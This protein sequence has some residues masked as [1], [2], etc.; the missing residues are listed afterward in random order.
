VPTTVAGFGQRFADD[1]QC[2]ADHGEVAAGPGGLL[3]LLDCREVDGGGSG[4]C[5]VHDV[6]L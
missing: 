5:G 1:L 3:H 4:G 2:R 6:F